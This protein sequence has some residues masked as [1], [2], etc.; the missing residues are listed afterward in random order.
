MLTPLNSVLRVI[1]E[2]D[3][4]IIQK[5]DGSSA[6]IVPLPFGGLYLH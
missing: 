3:I 6:G 2:N 1:P 5:R 4:I